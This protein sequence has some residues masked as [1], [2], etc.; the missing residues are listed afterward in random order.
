MIRKQIK[1]YDKKFIIL[2]IHISNRKKIIKSFKKTAF[3]NNNKIK[4]IK[5]I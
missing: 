5:I 4:K 2:E 1:I 3:I